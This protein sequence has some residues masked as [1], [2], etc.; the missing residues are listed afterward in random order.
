MG[1]R[2]GEGIGPA[3]AVPEG[4]ARDRPASKRISVSYEKASGKEKIS[5]NSG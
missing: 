2:I 1:G 3:A 4:V 5:Y